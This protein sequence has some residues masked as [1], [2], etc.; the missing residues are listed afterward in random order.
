[1]SV[2][3][4]V[5]TFEGPLDLLLQLVEQEKLDI[6]NVSLA[7]VAEQFIAHVREAEQAIPLEELADFLVVAA[8]L[9]YLKSKL[10]LPELTDETLD[11]GP[12]LELHLKRYR[13]FVEASKHIDALWRSGLRSYGRTEPL[14]LPRTAEIRI[15]PSVTREGL[16]EAM[17]RVIQRLEPLRRLPQTALERTVSIQEKIRHL[18]SRVQSLAKLTFHEY[19]GAGASRADRVVSFLALLELVKQ[20]FLSVSQ[21]ELFHDIAIEAHPE[22]P[23][24]TPQSHSFV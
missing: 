8:K 11:E 6:S 14:T 3:F 10:L 7:R 17:R 13:A 21:E 24:A 1:M 19:V 4:R 23:Q 9:M 18:L 15:P 12:D 16:I 20:R 5:E 22:A 2:T